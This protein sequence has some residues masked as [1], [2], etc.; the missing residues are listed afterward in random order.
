MTS[1]VR[2]RIN[3]TIPECQRCQTKKSINQFVKGTRFQVAKRFK[4][5]LADNRGCVDLE[6]LGV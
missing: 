5:Y 1:A 2:P 3:E 4:D 6:A